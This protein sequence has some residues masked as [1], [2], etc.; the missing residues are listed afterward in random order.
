MYQIIP[1]LIKFF[2]SVLGP[3]TCIVDVIIAICPAVLNIAIHISIYFCNVDPGS[4]TKSTSTGME[5]VERWS[6]GIMK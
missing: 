1:M 4:S 2:V 6:E 5:R 3:W